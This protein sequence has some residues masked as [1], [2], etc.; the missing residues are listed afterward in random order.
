MSGISSDRLRIASEELKIIHK[1]LGG[2]GVV[3]PVLAY[4]VQKK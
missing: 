2:N 3:F 4:P 1:A